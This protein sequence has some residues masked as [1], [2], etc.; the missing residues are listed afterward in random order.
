MPTLDEIAR[1]TVRAAELSPSDRIMLIARCAGVLLTLSTANAA[2][3]EDSSPPRAPEKRPVERLL[4]VGEVS[5][6]LG[7]A[8]SHIYELLR[9]GSLK[10]VHVGKYWKVRPE[11]LVEF[12]SYHERIAT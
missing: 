6:A 12:I 4:G 5:Q 9:N 10:G 8:R 11:A 1:D 7:L 2:A 3:L